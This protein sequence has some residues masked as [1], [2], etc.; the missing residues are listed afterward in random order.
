MCMPFSPYVCFAPTIAAALSVNAFVR[1]INVYAHTR[2][3]QTSAAYPLSMAYCCVR[4]RT[5]EPGCGRKYT[6]RVQQTHEASAHVL[7]I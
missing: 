6:S 2:C 7:Q 1:T 3:A 4:A 5:R